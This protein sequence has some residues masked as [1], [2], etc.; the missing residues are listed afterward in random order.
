MHHEDLDA[1][2]NVG[3]VHDHLAVKAARAQQGRVED[4]GAVGA[5]EDDDARRAC[6]A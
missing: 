5:R 3:L 4:V 2:V 6:E 1:P